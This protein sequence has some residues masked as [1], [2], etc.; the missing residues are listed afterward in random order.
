VRCGSREV[1][2]PDL[3]EQALD[4]HDLVPA[5]KQGCE[6]SPLLVSAELERASPDLGFERAENAKPERF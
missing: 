1:I 3:V 2:A 5:E 6:N 4:G